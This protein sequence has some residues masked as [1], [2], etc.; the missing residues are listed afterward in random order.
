MTMFIHHR[1]HGLTP[2]KVKLKTKKLRLYKDPVYKI[3]WIAEE[4]LEDNST[5]T[6]GYSTWFDNAVHMIQ[7]KC[8]ELWNV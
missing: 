6:F 7:L 8:K 2:W 3:G 4:V 5:Y 1:I